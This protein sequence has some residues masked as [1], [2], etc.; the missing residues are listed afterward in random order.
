[1]SQGKI[2]WIQNLKVNF[3]LQHESIPGAL[4]IQVAPR[5]PSEFTEIIEHVERADHVILIFIK[6]IYI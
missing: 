3:L 1:M 2:G 4:Q 5:G 6:K